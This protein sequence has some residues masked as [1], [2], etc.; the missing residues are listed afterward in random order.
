ML[1]SEGELIDEEKAKKIEKAGIRSVVIRAPAT[2]KAPKGICAKC[3]GLNMA[4]NRLVKPGEAV[5]IIAAQSIGEPG[6]QLTLRTFHTGGRLLL[7]KRK[8]ILRLL[9][10]GLLDITTLKPI[11]IEREKILSLIEEMQVFSWLFQK[12]KLFLM[13][14]Y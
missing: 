10:R 5:G 2:C 1:L 14:N 11:K 3:Y 4:E 13:E 6:T 7:E 8:E 9:K 12:L